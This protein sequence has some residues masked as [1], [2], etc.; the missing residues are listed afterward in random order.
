MG[1]VLRPRGCRGS[2]DGGGGGSRNSSD[3]DGGSG[4]VEVIIDRE[5]AH[6][7]EVGH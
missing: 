1:E 3:S 5:H 6:V 4:I 7:G 2:D